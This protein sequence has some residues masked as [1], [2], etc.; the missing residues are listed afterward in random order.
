MNNDF[1][2]YWAECLTILKNQITSV[3]F[4]SVI[5]PL[6]L[7]S[8]QDDT[9]IFTSTNKTNINTIETRYS[10]VIVNTLSNI[11]GKKVSIKIFTEEQFNR[12]G[13][14]SSK[15]SNLLLDET[16]STSKYTFDTF[17]RGG[18]NDMAYSAALAVAQLPDKSPYNP[19]FLYGGVGLG[20]THLMHSISNYIK[21]NFKNK[22]VLYLSSETFM[23]ELIQS[24]QYSKNI[25]FREKYR[26]LDV[27]LID[28]IQF[29]EGKE[30]TQEEFFHT[31]NALYDE[32]KLIVISS[33]KP[34]KDLKVLEERLRSRFSMGLPVDIKLPDFETRTAILEKKAI[35]EKIDINNEVTQFIAKNISSNIRDLE[36]A[37]NC[38]SAYAKLEGGPITI[39]IAKRALQNLF[40][41]PVKAEITIPLIQEI[42]A[43]YYNITRDEINTKNR[44]KRIAYPRQIAMYLSRRL[45][46]ESLPKIGAAFNRDHT[47]IIHG[48]DKIAKEAKINPELQSILLS[49]EVSIVGEQ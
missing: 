31:F 27:L 24:I 35:I 6:K 49:L 22:K 48:C 1:T 37:L 28:D 18:S 15:S 13:L 11:V 5:E 47:T 44:S 20:K 45:V 29:I 12:D 2:V 8:F 46:D 16:N 7:I 19:L 10:Q 33:D 38:V 32:S 39:D 17:V 30:S 26:K 14:W 3:I 43:N 9:F 34:P 40:S 36:G 4:T 41:E 21:N 42:V 23:N 25:E